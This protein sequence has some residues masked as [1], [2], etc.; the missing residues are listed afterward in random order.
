M[1]ITNTE[2]VKVI[3]WSWVQPNMLASGFVIVWKLIKRHGKMLFADSYIQEILS[4]DKNIGS[5]IS[6]LKSVNKTEYN[7]IK[8]LI[9]ITKNLAPDYKIEFQVGSD[10]QNNNDKIAKYIGD[11]FNKSTVDT[12]L[13]D[14]IWV[15]ISGEGRY[16]KKD[17]DSDLQKILWK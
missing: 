15:S 11:K 1:K 17:L 12:K 7:D 10:S 13:L 14:S 8:K 9:Q 2:L 16:F 3:L 6:I 5:I 4:I